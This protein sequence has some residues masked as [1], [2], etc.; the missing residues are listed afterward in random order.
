MIASIE[1]PMNIK[2]ILQAKKT[3]YQKTGIPLNELY[4]IQAEDEQPK[5]EECLE[6]TEW[7]YKFE[8]VSR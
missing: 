8:V 1:I 4:L 3:I 5:D 2:T 6:I 7:K